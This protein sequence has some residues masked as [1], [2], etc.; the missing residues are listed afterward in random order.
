MNLTQLSSRQRARITRI[1]GA[2][3]LRQRLV[4]LGVL[5]GLSIS[6][7]ATSLWGNPRT[8]IIGPQQICL[9]S[10]E[11]GCIEIEVVTS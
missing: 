4:A 5:R 2:D 3:A 10:E 9:R 6:V 1:T 8:Y 7:G 11:A